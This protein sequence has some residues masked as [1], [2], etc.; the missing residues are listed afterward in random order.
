MCKWLN[1]KEALK[2]RNHKSTRQSVEDDEHLEKRLSKGFFSKRMNWIVSDGQSGLYTASANGHRVRLD[3]CASGASEMANG[4][5]TAALKHICTKR[6]V[7]HEV[8]PVSVTAWRQASANLPA[9]LFFFWYY[10]LPIG[11]R[12]EKH[13]GVVRMQVKAH[14]WRCTNGA[15]F[16][17]CQCAYVSNLLIVI[18]TVPVC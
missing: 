12:W 18:K 4:Q 13:L 1:W 6:S 9:C 17:A 7:A 16:A 14:W 3:S 11:Q 15:P 8:L 5:V 10:R 2:R